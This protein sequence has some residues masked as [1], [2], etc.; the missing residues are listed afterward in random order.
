VIGSLF[1]IGAHH[2]GDARNF[3][4]PAVAVGQGSDVGV[5]GPLSR[6]SACAG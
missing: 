4:D 2:L 6:R 5:D 3:G 1:L